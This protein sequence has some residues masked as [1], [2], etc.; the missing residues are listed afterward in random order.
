MFEFFLFYDAKL[1]IENQINYLLFSL[2]SYKG[3][4]ND[5]PLINCSNPSFS[6][7]DKFDINKNRQ[8]SLNSNQWLLDHQ[9][10]S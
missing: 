5:F 6:N 9:S 3:V 4:L 8:P 2:I 1:L 10:Y 7:K